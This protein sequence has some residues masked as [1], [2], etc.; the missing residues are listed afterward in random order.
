M[1]L[2][3]EPRKKSPVTPPGIDPG[4]VRLVIGSKVGNQAK[5]L[6]YSEKKIFCTSL[7]QMFERTATDLNR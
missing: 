4:A 6:K 1:V 3:G 5:P 7:E 2:S